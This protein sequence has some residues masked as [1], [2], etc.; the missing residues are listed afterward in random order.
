MAILL[1]MLMCTMISLSFLSKCIYVYDFR[2]KR[3]TSS[4]SNWNLVHILR[5]ISILF[6]LIFCALIVW[7]ISFYCKCIFLFT[8]SWICI[9]YFEIR[10][11]VFFVFFFLISKHNKTKIPTAKLKIAKDINRKKYKLHKT[12]KGKDINKQRIQ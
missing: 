1:Y 11:D 10:L 6:N 9:Y 4:F 7:P 5:S 2:K 3:K 8:M 12:T